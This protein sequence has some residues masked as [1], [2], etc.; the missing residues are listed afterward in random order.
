MSDGPHRS[1]NMRRA[2]KQIAERA[3]K[4]AFA[5]E[6][7]SE[8]LPNALEQDW[9]AEI[10]DSLFRQIR[11]ILNDEQISLFGDQRAQ[12]LEG[13]R[14]ETAGYP[15]AGVFLDCAIQ[16]AA[17]GR[18]GEPAIRAAAYGAL[19]DCAARGARQ[20][21]EHYRRESSEHRATN[22]RGRIEIGLAQANIAGIADRL[23]GIGSGG[24][25]RAPQKQTGLDDGVKL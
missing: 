4:E 2:W 16:E 21:E 17:R 22:V 25:Q 19:S 24:S 7:V 18:S 10:S 3:D 20:V 15:L 9:R 1:L 5:P 11:K 8:V 6:E 14:T 12:Q 13:L 23:T